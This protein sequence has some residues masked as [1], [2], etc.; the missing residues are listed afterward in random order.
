MPGLSSRSAIA[1]TSRSTS[2]G[3]K[4]SGTAS[5]GRGPAWCQSRPSNLI[6]SPHSAQV[7]RTTYSRPVT[8][9]SL[10]EAPCGDAA[11]GPRLPP[12][13]PRAHSRVGPPSRSPLNPMRNVS[14]RGDAWAGT[15]T[16]SRT[17]MRVRT[18]SPIDSSFERLA[19]LRLCS[20]WGSSTTTCSLS[21]VHSLICT[22]LPPGAPLRRRKTDPA[23][24]SCQWALHSVTLHNAQCIKDTEAV[25]T[26]CDGGTVASWQTRRNAL[27]SG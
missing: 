22:H 16:A 5:C 9:A 2:I 11:T 17:D 6:A 13:Q 25:Q 26:L 24:S 12:G 19:I 10:A 20:G 4:N 1:I 7:A 15:D 3:P 18:A 8:T 23:H 27:Q 21:H 14:A